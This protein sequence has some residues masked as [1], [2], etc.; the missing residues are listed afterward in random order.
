[1]K[2]DIENWMIAHKLVLWKTCML[3][4]ILLS[5][6]G[7]FSQCGVII[8]KKVGELSLCD[9]INNDPTHLL[10]AISPTCTVCK[11]SYL[12]TRE[13]CENIGVDSDMDGIADICDLDD[14]NDGILDIVEGK[15]DEDS[16]IEWTHNTNG[17]QGDGATYTPA[18]DSNLYTSAADIV[19]GS[20]LD[21]SV[22]YA[23]TYLLDDADATDFTGAK[24]DN[25]YLQFSYVPVES[26]ILDGIGLGF[27]TSAASNPEFNVGN[28][29]IAIE[30]SDNLAFNNPTLLFQDIQIGNM[31]APNGYLSEFNELNNFVLDAGTPAI[32]RFYLY[33]EQNSGPDGRV[34]FDDLVFPHQLLSSCDQDTDGD[35]IVNRL[36]LDSDGDG[37]PDAIEGDGGFSFDNTLN[38]LLTGG[39][40]SNGLPLI[41]GTNGQ[42]IGSSCDSTLYADAC[43]DCIAMIDQSIDICSLLVAHPIH[44]IGMEDCDMGGIDNKTECDNVG[45][46]ND[47]CDD[48]APT[49]LCPAYQTI[50][51][52][53]C[54]LA[55]GNYTND[56][57]LMDACTD[58]TIY[59]FTQSPLIGT[60]LPDGMHTITL[61]VTDVNN[62][63]ANC[64]FIVE[65]DLIPPPVP[66][67][68]GN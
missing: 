44:P 14:D 12:E 17:G 49:I 28:F 2:I 68:S 5:T 15:C 39:V 46:P 31:I 40:A 48:T 20:G 43:A 41:A 10:A 60:I 45:N 34:R 8:I 9:R 21:E 23:F 57:E 4:I 54:G 52:K 1:M 66:T 64:T 62:N 19:I 47:D 16:Q 65:L 63:T 33:D 30:Y 3:L 37:C 58:L 36:D 6:I 24:V 55:L 59:T 56:I 29:K 22:N 51:D 53:G 61:M 42:A 67:I 27:F 25:D 32:F 7:L 38:G 26:M 11:I 18:E 50:T 35:G 13:D